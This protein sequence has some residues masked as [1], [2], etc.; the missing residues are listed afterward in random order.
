[1]YRFLLYMFCLVSMSMKAQSF[2]KNEMQA[3]Y[4][5][6]KTPYK[7]GLVVAP[8]DNFHKF[9]CPTIYKENGIWYMTYVVYNGKDGLD[10]RG[11]EIGRAHV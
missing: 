10:G 11:Y 2:D 1:M 3:I 4:E 6:V 7:F 8:Q 5:E 9:D